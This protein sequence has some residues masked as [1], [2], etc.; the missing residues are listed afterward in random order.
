MQ[1][2]LPNVGVTPWSCMQWQRCHC[3][4]ALPPL[5]RTRA[6]PSTPLGTGQDNQ[7]LLLE[8]IGCV[9][10]PSDLIFLLLPPYHR[11]PCTAAWPSQAWAMQLT[12][13]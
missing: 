5:A 12:G 10:T 7:S 11:C 13:L 9:N 4:A 8:N 2:P 1:R 3:K 6:K